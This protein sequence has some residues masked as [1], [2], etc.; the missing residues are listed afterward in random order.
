MLANSG[1]LC[2]YVSSSVTPPPL[3]ISIA[4]GESSQQRW[5]ERAAKIKGD[6]R[7][8]KQDVKNDGEEKGEWGWALSVG[9]F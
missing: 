9:S 6:G 3:S 8:K 4:E 5:L 2:T 7:K 1:K